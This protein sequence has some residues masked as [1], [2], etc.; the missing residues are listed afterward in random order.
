MTPLGAVVRGLV[1]GAAGTAA[2][3]ALLYARYRRG[4]GEEGFEPWE[5]SSDVDSWE[6]APAPAQVGKRLVEGLFERELPPQRAR[7]VNNITHW[8]YGILGGVQYGI[9]AGSLRDTA[10]PVRAAVRR[11][12]VGG[13]IRRIAGRQALQADLEVR[14]GHVDQGSER[15]PGVRAGNRDRTA[16]A[17]GHDRSSV[18]TATRTSHEVG[19]EVA[20]LAKGAVVPTT[21]AD[22]M[23]ATL[24]A[25][26][27]RRV[28]GLPGDSINGF[29]D[30]L[31]RDGEVVWEHVR[32]EEAAAFAAAGEAAMTGQLA[33]CAAS[34][35]PGN[36]HLINGLFDAN[37]S[38]VPVLA[39][40]AH[41]PREEIGGSYFQETHPQE[42]FRECSVYAELVSVPEQ[43]PR[44]LEIAMRHA[45]ER[46]G[47]AVV[48]VPGEI[49]LH[50]VAHDA[51]PGRDRA[52]RVG[53]FVPPT[54]RWPPWRRRSTPPSGS[55]SWP[56]PA[57][58]APTT[59]SSRSPARSRRPSSIRCGARS[60]SSTTTPTTSG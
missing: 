8:A 21:V 1:A 30:A 34:C 57:A 20:H 2:M 45:I 58:A 23:V 3:D 37:R 9:V 15:P 53:R 44:V 26:G 13:G 29:T 19:R 49:F 28:Y 60:S 10:H 11:R 59:S 31:R 7:L 54:T 51:P 50:H 56:A 38:R 52:G 39:I 16:P 17:C 33:V 4:H 18:M 43:L 5:F 12:R 41:I 6:K 27:V 46:G 24:K 25:S 47:V 42:L 35:G 48:V 40:A 22:V 36:L 14:P 32:H 55:R